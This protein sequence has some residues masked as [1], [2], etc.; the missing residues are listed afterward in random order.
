[1]SYIVIATD[2]TIRREDG[3]PTLDAIDAIVQHGGWARVQ[4]SV[5]YAMTGWV[6][7][8]GLITGASR[9]PVGSCVLAA[10]GA[11]RQPY[12]GP[13]VIT[14]YDHGSDW[15]GPGPLGLE[16]AGAL[17][18]VATATRSVLDDRPDAPPPPSWT[19]PEWI[20]AI[21]AHA[22]EIRADEAPEIRILTDAEAATY[23]GRWLP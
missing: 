11:A 9:N 20:A 8:C 23:L 17:D 6:S 21:R 14:G 2:G 18:R 22:E 13:V 3:T 1:M 15:G 16:M 10:F 19:T 4:L 12:A 5:Q 7:D